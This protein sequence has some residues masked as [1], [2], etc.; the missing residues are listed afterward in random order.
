MSPEKKWKRTP[1]TISIVRPQSSDFE[2][3]GHI[4]R[5]YVRLN[6]ERMSFEMSAEDFALALTGLSE[7]PVVLVEREE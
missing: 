3:T 2:S 7:V 1:G 6:G 4:I 5:L